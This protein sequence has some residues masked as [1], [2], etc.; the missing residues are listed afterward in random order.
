MGEAYELNGELYTSVE[1]FLE[2]LAYEYKHG[3]KELVLSLL[4]DYGFEFSDLGV[5]PEGA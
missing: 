3:D 5:R 2:A 4:D 1:A